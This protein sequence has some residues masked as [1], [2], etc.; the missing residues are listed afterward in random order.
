[1]KDSPRTLAFAA[2]LA[3]CCASL[4][5]AANHFLRPYQLANEQAHH[6]RNVLDV[7]GVPYDAAAGSEALVAAAQRQVRQRDVAGM[8]VYAYAP[9]GGRGVLRAV[10]FAGPGLWGPVEGLLCFEGDLRTI[11]AVRFYKH[12]E[13]PG[14]GAK[15]ETPQFT[16]QF[17]GKAPGEGGIRFVRSGAAG[18]SEVDA[19]T[20]AT[21][22]CDKVAAMLNDALARVAEHRAEILK[23]TA[24][25]R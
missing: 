13:T 3:L 24:D 10:E 7:L 16:D 4:L 18:D 19:I 5:T 12:E 23:E 20:G 6:W 11:R 15:I 8:K 17:R 2:V 22:T 14:L 25:V 1:M 9:P 21:L